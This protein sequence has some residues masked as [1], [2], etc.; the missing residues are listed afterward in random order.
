MKKII[1]FISLILIALAVFLAWFI[2]S[3]YIGSTST[4]SV[5]VNIPEGATAR[6]VGDVLAQKGVIVSSS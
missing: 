2:P 3:A 4:L 5:P 1:L 6:Q